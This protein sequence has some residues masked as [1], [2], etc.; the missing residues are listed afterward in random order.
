MV[1]KSKN[2]KKGTI[3][4]DNMSSLLRRYSLNTVIAL[5]KEVSQ[6][7]AEKINWQEVVKNTTTGISG[8]R[9]YQMLWRH[10]A[11]GETLVDQIDHDQN[12]MDDD[13]DLEYELE[14]FPTVGREASLEAAAC[15]RVLIA[16]G[17]TNDSHLPSSS[18][19]EGPLTINIPNRHTFSAPLDSSLF[20]NAMQG[21][22]VSI[23][24]SLQK[25]PSFSGLSGEKRPNNEASGV[26]L[27]PRRKRRC[28]SV[29]EDL[30][31]TAAANKY[32][33]PN[34]AN[35]AR[36]DFN[37]D[38]KPSELSQRWTNLRRKQSNLKVGVISQH[39]ETQLAASNRAVS[40]ALDT[41]MVEMKSQHQLRK[42]CASPDQLLGRGGPPKPLV[43][44]K[45]PPMSPTPTP[46]SMV[47]AAAV[48]AGARIATQADASSL[49]E[50]TRSQN[51]V[52][53]TTGGGPVMRSNSTNL[54][55]QLPSNVHF[56]R[57]GLVKA[58]I[59][60]YSAA[61]QSLPQPAPVQKSAVDAVVS[62]SNNIMEEVVAVVS[63][64]NNIMEEVVQQAPGTQSDGFGDQPDEVDRHV[65]SIGQAKD[66]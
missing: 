25:V 33:E 1:D 51:V 3:S 15:V 44:T 28:W 5:L 32:G 60:T 36:M 34:W 7:A 65:N 37:D 29:E 11:Y 23:P 26:S 59:S 45:N 6:V 4:E 16:S 20:A 56:I 27:P 57:N 66:D 35:V 8:A 63:T 31:L 40:L 12:P 43:V 2:R 46:D 17:C 13:S 41:P 49:I 55:N 22:N 42:P 48:A 14:P 10:L 50:A 62:T 47:K 9:E 19:I 53:I 54:T 24:V 39:P 18:T 64:S 58:P 30:K 61:R 21:T 38:R 52:H